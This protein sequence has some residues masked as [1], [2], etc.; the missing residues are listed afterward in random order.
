MKLKKFIVEQ[1]F[2]FMTS[3]NTGWPKA[4]IPL[5]TGNDNMADVGNMKMPSYTLECIF[6]FYNRQ[7]TSCFKFELWTITIK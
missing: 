2:S 1:A 4:E 5:S 6:T 3:N 7:T